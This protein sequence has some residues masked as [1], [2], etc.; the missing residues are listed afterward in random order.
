M[1]IGSQV[2][3]LEPFEKAYTLMAELVRQLIADGHA[4]VMSISAGDLAYPIAAPMTCP[5]R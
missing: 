3:T 2:T 4:S 5:R 1:H